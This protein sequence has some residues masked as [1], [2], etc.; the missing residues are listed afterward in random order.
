MCLDV[1]NK[2]IGIYIPT[3]PG[4]ILNEN[5][6]S[7]AVWEVLYCYKQLLVLQF[8]LINHFGW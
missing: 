7:K 6:I 1:S 3:L 4:T 8:L 2:K 5:L